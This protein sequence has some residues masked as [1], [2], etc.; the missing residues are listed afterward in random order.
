[1]GFFPYNSAFRQ[2]MALPI[3]RSDLVL[4]IAP[5][6]VTRPQRASI[7]APSARIVIYNGSLA[8]P[9]V[10]GFAGDVWHGRV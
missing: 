2:L 8:N 9:A 6:V 7:Q 10:D 4:R 3:R 1:M 5:G